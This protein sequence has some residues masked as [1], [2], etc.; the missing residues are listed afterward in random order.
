MKLPAFWSAVIFITG[1]WMGRSFNLP[2][3]LLF[4][5]AITAFI[6][7]LIIYLKHRDKYAWIIIAAALF[8]AGVFRI[9][10]ESANIPDNDISHFNDMGEYITVVGEIV[11]EP[12]LRP[13]QT[14]LTVRADTIAIDKTRI[15]VSGLV[16]IRLKYPAAHFNYADYV[17]VRGYLSAPQP[18]RNPGAFD[19]R[20]YLAN[21]NIHSLISVSKSFNI[22]RIRKQTGNVFLTG[23][24]IPLRSYILKTFE[25]F[26]SKPNSALISGFLIGETRFIPPEIFQNF[27]DT[28]TLHL[29]AVSGSN[30]VL[31]TGTVAF[32]L[33]L[34]RIRLRSRYLLSF[35][36]IIIFCYLSYNQP[37]VVRASVMVGLY[38][39]GRLAYRKINYISVIAASAI[40]ILMFAPLMLWDVGFQLSFA[41]AF[42]LIYFLP[43][44]FGKLSFG[45]SRI[46]KLIQFVVMIFFS[47]LIAQLAVAPILA[48]SFHTIPMIGILSNLVV[49]P[50]SS[51]AVILALIL[52]FVGWLAPMAQVLGWLADF[53]LSWTIQAVNFFASIPVIKFQISTPA[54]YLIIFYYLILFL[55]FNLIINR[56]VFKYL[57]ITVLTAA[58]FLLWSNIIGEYN[59]KPS[60]TV[61][62][63]G[64]NRMILVET[65]Q[66]ADYLLA[67]YRSGPEYDPLERVL[68]PYLV[69]RRIRAIKYFNFGDNEN[70]DSLPI[71][72]DK[73]GIRVDETEG[74]ADQTPA[75]T[76]ALIHKFSI[77]GKNIVILS[78]YNVLHRLVEIDSISAD[79]L[80]LPE[81]PLFNLDFTA[82]IL[83]INPEIIIFSGYQS[84][85]VEPA[86]Y[87]KF[88]ENI[89][90]A[91]I[92]CY[93]TR[94]NGAVEIL[95]KNG[96]IAAHPFFQ[97]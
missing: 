91:D 72:F 33:L 44:I 48:Y 21:K 45:N 18:A 93:N 97:P 28:G 69:E 9:N 85:Y 75:E 64:S 71:L 16:L 12:D 26:V 34:L 39:L 81:P 87:R 78:D 15:P 76:S 65:G 32:I 53:V 51:L 82:L 79:I 30:V 52:C 92:N 50:L 43:I 58:N 55:L 77:N 27:R 70:S 80:I 96:R 83:K 35:L 67:D 38:I 63:C 89:F 1:I 42:G 46:S 68:L 7:G 37:S 2:D 19:Y 54:W 31:V 60:L 56:R 29:L 5:V 3:L 88:F 47:S 6:A 57:I 17:Q 25:S 23:F 74:H 8:I 66:Q 10:L 61:L 86:G 36:V 94:I 62:D 40:V 13:E 90:T 22:Y 73:S 84:L 95:F 20:K 49:V 11:R 24:I 4:L 14:Y 59:F 41:A